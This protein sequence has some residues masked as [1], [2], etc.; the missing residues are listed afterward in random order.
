MDG[1]VIGIGRRLREVRGE[2]TLPKFAD[3]FGVH[4]S[5]II[6]WEAETQYPNA[7]V[8]FTI[9]RT[10]SISATWLLTGEGEKS[11]KYEI[12]GRDLLLLATA[13][14]RNAQAFGY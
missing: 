3:T 12:D 9:C 8:L 10:E 14:G 1:G 6:R 4:K 2:R 7:L 13:A 5:S 11:R